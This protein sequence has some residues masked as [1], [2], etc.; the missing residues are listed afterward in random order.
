MEV[1]IKR[2]HNH[3]I[4]YGYGR[5]GE[6]IAGILK[7]QGAEFVVI[8]RNAESIGKAQQADCLTIVDDTTR[9]EVLRRARVDNARGLITALGSDADNTYTTLAA[10]ELNS[11]LPIIAR[12]GDEDA[13]RKSQHAGANR[14]VAPEAI[15]GHQMAR[16]ALRPAAVEFIETVLFSQE[17]QLLVEEDRSR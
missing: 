16:L 15:G 12:A 11:T 3:F 5:V 9:D 13:Q 4:L 10:R 6:A 2:L 14:V 1:K 17:Q 8:D 7:Q